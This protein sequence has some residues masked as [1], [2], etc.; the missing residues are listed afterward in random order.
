MRAH[1]STVLCK[2][3]E[4]FLGGWFSRNVITQK[5]KVWSPFESLCGFSLV[6]IHARSF[7][8]HINWRHSLQRSEIDNLNRAG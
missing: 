7:L 1:Y 4:R 6:E 3:Q 2:R 5:A 8:P